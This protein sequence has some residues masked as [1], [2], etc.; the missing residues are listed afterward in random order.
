MDVA[1]GLLQGVD[2]AEPLLI[3]GLIEPVTDVGGHVVQAGQLGA[4]QA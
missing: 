1:Q 4:V 2:L 3:A